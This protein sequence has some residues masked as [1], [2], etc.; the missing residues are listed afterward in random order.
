M[1]PAGWILLAGLW[2]GAGAA[3]A[4]Q[5]AEAVFGEANEHFRQ[6][7]DLRESDP[8]AAAELY[9]RAARRYETLVGEF[10]IRNSK[11][12][13]NLGNAYFQLGDT[14]RAI[15]NYLLAQRL[16]PGDANVTRNLEFAR[17]SRTDMLDSSAGSPALETLLFWHFEL[18]SAARLRLFAGSVDRLLG[19]AAASAGRQGMGAPRDRARRG[20]CRRAHALLA[21]LGSAGGKPHCSRGGGRCGDG[22]APGR[23]AELRTGIRGSSARRSRVPGPGGAPGLAQGGTAGRA[24]LLAPGRGHSTRPL[25]AAAAPLGRGALPHRTTI[26]GEPGTRVPDDPQARLR[27]RTR[28]P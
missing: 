18:S 13:Y 1:R 17:A 12:H 27:D 3:L 9:R 15:L 20:G 23:R 26:A 24:E 5:G 16:D 11:L 14:G 8:E 7:T 28:S 10:G 21:R 2:L 6:A 19:P 25:G 4:Q 22:R